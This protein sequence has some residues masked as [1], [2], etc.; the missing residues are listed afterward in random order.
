MVES[1]IYK[2]NKG[3]VCREMTAESQRLAGLGQQSLVILACSQAAGLWH[4]G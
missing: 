4:W 2:N 3:C 1:M